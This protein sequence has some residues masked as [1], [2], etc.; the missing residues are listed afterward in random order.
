MGRTITP[1]GLLKF[2]GPLVGLSA[3]TAG[4]A[5]GEWATR[6]GHVVLPE[7]SI[8]QPEHI[9]LRAHTNFKMFVPAAGMAARQTS[10]E[11]VP[12]ASGPPFAGYFYETPAS[13]A[14]VYKLVSSIDAG[15]NPNTV[16]ANPTGGS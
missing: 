7:S 8:E 1:H 14:Y 10:P 11:A 6:G 15:C 12:Q 5:S 9:G 16:F 3:L 4:E 2:I 13:L